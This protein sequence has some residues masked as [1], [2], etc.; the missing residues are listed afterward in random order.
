MIALFGLL[1]TGGV[2]AQEEM[3]DQEVREIPRGFDDL[4]LGLSLEDT[5]ERLQGNTNFLYRG[6]PDVS[7]RPFDQERSIETEGRGYMERGAF[8]F[9]EDFLYII[10]L[11]LNRERLDYFTIYRTL[12][13]KYG[14]PDDLS[15]EAAIW[16]DEA[17]RMSLERP[18]TVKYVDLDRFEAQIEEGEMGE[19]LRAQMREIFLEQF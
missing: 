16:E 11:F 2:S 17:T 9:E 8:L 18:L 10:T 19:S 15:P 6:A 3:V 14:D 7:L 12:Q 5:R 13:S 1:L 4:L